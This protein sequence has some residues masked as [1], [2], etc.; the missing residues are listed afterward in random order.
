MYT[1]KKNLHIFTLAVVLSFLCFSCAKKRSEQE[2][3]KYP[4]IVVFLADDWSWPHASIYAESDSVIKTPTF[5]SIARNGVLF[6]QA[7]TA[8]PSCAPSRAALL[9]GQYPHRLQD[10][11]NLWSNFPKKFPVYTSILEKAGYQLGLSGKGW[12]PGNYET[13]GWKH[14]PAGKRYKNFENFYKQKGENKPFCFWF[15][16]GDPHRPYVKDSGIRSGMDSSK[17]KVPPYLPDNEIVRKDIL[18]YYYEVERFDREV[19]EILDFLKEKGELE[20]TLVI[21]TS[22][23]GWPFPRAKAN[24][25]DEGTHMPLA[26]MWANQIEGGQVYDK[27]I[28]SIDIAPTVLDAAHQP[29]LSDMNGRSILRQLKGENQRDHVFTERERHAYVRMNNLGYPSRALRTDDYLYIRNIKPDRWP[30]G[31]PE[32]IF[33]VGPFG[34]VDGSPTKDYI[35]S[36]QRNFPASK[37][38]GMEVYSYFDLAFKKRPAEELYDLEKDPY[39]IKNVAA[40]PMYKEVIR[41]YRK[42]LDEW[43]VNTGDPRATGDA[44]FDQ[45]P[46]YGGNGGKGNGHGNVTGP[47]T[48]I[49]K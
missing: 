30:S 16:S 34:D 10:A 46:Y 39:Q 47:P 6:T 3:Q 21:M 9:T 15:G 28:N 18:D 2:K 22:D 36:E 45:Y 7:F 35:L 38:E 48:K 43:M 44:K 11:A 32:E 42:S 40:D 1:K 25:Y 27:F 37:K 4:N 19:G 41:N 31:D 5:D 49:N 14:N 12:K 24:L 33:A 20:N 26:I 29:I 8:A 23:N 13:T 17:V